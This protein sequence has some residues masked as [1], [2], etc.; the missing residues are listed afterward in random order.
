MNIFNS[1]E[2]ESKIIEAKK[3]LKNQINELVKLII[4]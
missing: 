2:I 3:L 1:K 4:S